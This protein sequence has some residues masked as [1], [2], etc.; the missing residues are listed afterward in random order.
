MSQGIDFDP[1]R[2]PI[3]GGKIIKRLINLICIYHNIAPY[4]KEY[5]KMAE[6]E[7]DLLI[8]IASEWLREDDMGALLTMYK[9]P[10]NI[11]WEIEGMNLT[12]EAIHLCT[13]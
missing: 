12:E 6:D 2:T 11:Q 13:H 3:N 9:Y 4:D 10:R 1:L 5:L 8:G 7:I